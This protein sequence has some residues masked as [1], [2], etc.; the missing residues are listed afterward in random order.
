MNPV[1]FHL[2]MDA[3]FVSVERLRDPSLLGKPVVVG[4][5]RNERGVVSAASYEAR[6]FG[7]HSAM[8]LRNAARLCP[9]AI[10][11]PGDRKAYSHY[12]REVNAVL[13]QF[14]PK[15]DMASIDE[16]YLDMSGTQRLWGPPL[17]AAHKLHE[18]IAERTKLP[19]SIGIGS[20]RLVAK[21]A[22]DQAKPNGVLQI[23]PG[24]EAAWLAPLPV[25]RLPGIGKAT[26]EQLAKWNIRLL[27]ELARLDDR[28]LNTQF[29]KWGVDLAGKARGLDSGAW[30]SGFIGKE[31]DPRSISH[32]HT[33]TEDSSDGEML[34]ATLVRLTEKVMRRVRDQ[35][36]LAGVV[37]LKLRF[38]DFTTLTRAQ[39]LRS[40]S[41]IDRD[42]LEV[43]RRLFR[44]EWKA[45]QK[46]RLL[47]VQAS[48][49][50]S[51]D[52]GQESLL[53]A[54]S[55][56]RRRRMLKTVD[57]LRD[58]FGEKVVTSA[59]GLS[60]DHQARVH[61]QMQNDFE[62]L[63]NRGRKKQSDK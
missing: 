3:F 26:E 56:E 28:F 31:G 29:G 24:E 5:G 11:L 36:L 40:A 42:V 52:A 54:D 6:R 23:L 17:A 46:V 34:D 50:S 38:A 9:Q 63:P 49:F 59:G 45:G 35:Q 10:F 12:S 51:P 48:G 25:R 53:D 20:S 4:G 7:V 33:F 19:C 47:G 2:D 14:T 58:R 18:A 1:V 55:N 39:T 32:E 8:P 43:I 15:L 57:L 22:S 44:R 30:F 37:Q 41:D 60:G 16:A 62:N 21:V 27:G 13:Q 61:D